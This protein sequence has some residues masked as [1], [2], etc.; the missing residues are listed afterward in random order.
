MV[1]PCQTRQ[2]FWEFQYILQKIHM[3]LN[4]FDDNAEAIIIQVCGKYG[5][6]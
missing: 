5:D 4:I 1:F 3:I 2:V 6:F